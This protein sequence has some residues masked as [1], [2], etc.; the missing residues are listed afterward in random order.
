M[1][2]N[3]KKGNI[4]T[5]DKQTIVN[6]I[7]C[8]GVMGAGL[9]LECRLRYPDMHEKYKDYCDQNMIKIGSLWIYKTNNR[10]I[11]NFPT[12]KHW[13]DPSKKQYLH[14]GLKKFTQ[15]YKSRGIESIAFPVLGSDKGGIPQDES[16]DI[17]EQ[18]LSRIDLDIE[19]YIYD[20]EARDD[21]FG[22]VKDWLLS[23]NIQDI[24]K[25][26][27]IGTN[28]LETVTNALENPRI[29]QLNQLASVKGIGIKTL[30]KIYTVATNNKG[31]I[32]MIS[33]KPL[34]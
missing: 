3:I 19:I 6:T 20:P 2:L 8:V 21:I 30:E 7:N 5:T 28:Y 17:M 27:G 32:E 12:K 15:T 13:K 11:M 22:E 33:Q 31:S 10:L 23:N 1:S 26:T 16:L 9:A 4:F 24:S 34:F 29:V 25:A 14:E 18:Y